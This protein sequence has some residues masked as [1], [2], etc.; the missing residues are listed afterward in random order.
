MKEKTLIE[1]IKGLKLHHCT[2]DCGLNIYLVPMKGFNTSAVHFYTKFGGMDTRFEDSKTKEVVELPVGTAHFFEHKMFEMPDG[3][4]AMHKFHK[5]G[6]SCNAATGYDKTSYLFHGTS[7]FKENLEHLINYVLTPHFTD[8]NIA[9]EQG[10]IRTEIKKN[11][12]NPQSAL[13]ENLNKALYQKRGVK[14]SILGTNK[15]ISKITKEFL[16]SIHE[17]FYHPSHMGLIIVGDQTRRVFKYVDKIIDKKGI[18]YQKPPKIEHVDEPEEVFKKRIEVSKKVPLLNY[19]I[20][21]KKNIDINKD[22]K[23][24]LRENIICDTL[25]NTVFSDF[26]EVYYKLYSEGIIDKNFYS[27]YSEGRGFGSSF[28]GGISQDLDRTEKRLMEEIKRVHT[29]G[30]SEEDF[31]KV[32]NIFLGMF[33]RVFDNPASLVTQFLHY[34]NYGA[35]VFDYVPLME[36]VTIEDAN[37]MF[38]KHVDPDNCSISIVNPKK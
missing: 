17:K 19:L 33:L 30:L 20:G 29:N 35:S 23:E 25:V 31:N 26:S 5:N 38:R 24:V 34:N 8:K 14:Y 22:P 7:K 32:K 37:K 21:F 28:L 4:D 16:Y 27:S 9:K 3:S 6:A 11:K 13:F 36:T 18:S 1:P 2:L 12:D 15:S 10:I